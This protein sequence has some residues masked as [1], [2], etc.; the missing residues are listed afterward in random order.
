MRSAAFML[1]LGV[2]IGAT[3]TVLGVV[4]W[5]FAGI[6][7]ALEVNEGLAERA[8][9]SPGAD[10]EARR[11]NV[12]FVFAG[13]LNRAI[14][15]AWNRAQ[16]VLA[17]VSLLLAVLAG[18]RLWVTAPVLVATLIVVGLSFFLAP[19][20]ETRGRQLDFVPRTE[21]SRAADFETFDSL[22]KTYVGA[23][24]AKTVL[25]LAAAVLCLWQRR[26]SE[27]LAGR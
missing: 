22:H 6:S 12:I 16:L 23:E 13:E 26:R 2:W 20:I 14:I 10:R 17:G 1:F 7:R 11:A 24:G 18:S 3:G 27:E 8:A 25:L 21:P 4:A 5:N 19:E 15:A 9:L